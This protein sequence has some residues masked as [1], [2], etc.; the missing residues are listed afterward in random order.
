MKAIKAYKASLLESA[1]PK[2]RADGELTAEAFTLFENGADAAKV[3][4]ELR[5]T[6]DIARQLQRDWADL[7]GAIVVGG[8]IMQKIRDVVWSDDPIVTGDDLLSAFKEIDYQECACCK[9]VP[10]FCLY[11]FRD[12]PRQAREIA[13]RA[14]AAAESRRAQKS[15][16]NAAESAVEHARDLSKDGSLRPSRRSPPNERDTSFAFGS[17]LRHPS[18]GQRHASPPPLNGAES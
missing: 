9:R 8:I 3:A 7:K 16:R 10:K 13:A 11:C 17:R 5:T 14:I 12:R 2:T 1:P 4:V 18:C 15:E 6:A